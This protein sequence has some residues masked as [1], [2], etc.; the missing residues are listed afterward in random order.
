MTE[1]ALSTVPAGESPSNK[2]FA[3]L[4]GEIGRKAAGWHALVVSLS[5]LP[6][7]SD[8]SRLAP[9]VV[10]RTEA[11]LV[12][13]HGVLTMPNFDVCA[14]IR[15]PTGAAARELA[16]LTRHPAIFT[17]DECKLESKF[18]VTIA[19]LPVQ[20]PNPPI[21]LPSVDADEIAGLVL[22]SKVSPHRNRVLLPAPVCNCAS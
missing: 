2:V 15:E 20:V 6:G 17:V 21:K 8:R 12:Y 4:M 13:P 18:Q 16:A 10:E 22:A 9:K 7:R 19:G 1:V 3:A 5:R 14:L 11:A